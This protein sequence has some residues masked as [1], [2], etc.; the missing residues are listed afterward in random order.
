MFPENWQFNH[1]MDFYKLKIDV[2]ALIKI[3]NQEE[4]VKFIATEYSG[5]HP[6]QSALINIGDIN[7]GVIGALHPE[8]LIALDINN[9]VYMFE[10]DLNLMSE[11]IKLK[12]F[13]EISKFPAIRRDFSILIDLEIDANKIQQ[14]V[15]DICGKLLKE[16][17]FFDVYLGNKLPENKKSIAFGIILQHSQRTLIEQEIN[18]ISAKIINNLTFI[19]A[20]LRT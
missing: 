7:I 9:P 8:L 13:K 2:L 17:I 3:V 1:D 19:G 4:N 14:I 5:L 6:Y 18:E 15:Y 16:L 10:L 11:F 20:Q 12:K